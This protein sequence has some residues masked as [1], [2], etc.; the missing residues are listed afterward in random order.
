[1]RMLRVFLAGLHLLALALGMFA[2]IARGSAL[3]EKF[4]AASLQRAFR[5]DTMW[6]IAAVLWVGTGLWRLLG[7]IEKPA[8][9]YAAN[10]FFILKMALFLLVVALEAWPAVVLVRW[11]VAL[12]RG[13][14]PAALATRSVAQRI[15]L[16]S[17]VEATLVLVMILLAVAV[18]RGYDLSA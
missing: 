6:G 17:H 2:V 7:G 12:R 4:T 11:R 18:A 3:R 10:D 5:M 13:G 8:A 16:I 14:D 1:M 15:A 9:Y